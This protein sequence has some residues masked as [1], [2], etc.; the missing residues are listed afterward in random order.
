MRALSK[1]PEH[2]RLQR[3]AASKRYKER[4]AEKV[5]LSAR[6][7]RAIY[8][9]LNKEKCDA[10]RDEWAAKN[11][12]Y[13]LEYFKKYNNARKEKHKAYSKARY[14]AKNAE[15]KAQ[16]KEYR[17]RNSE[18]IKAD[19]A[20]WKS[21]NGERLK[22]SQAEYYQRSGKARRKFRRDTIPQVKIDS[23]CR[24]RIV[25]CLKNVGLK[26]SEKAETLLG[27]TAAFMK[28]FIEH[29]FELWMTWENW[30]TEWELD[31]TIPI[32][33]FDLTIKEQRLRAF[34]YSNCKPLRKI[35][36][37]MKNDKM[38]GPHQPLLI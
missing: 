23:C 7:Y 1:Y 6:K 11:R 2:I 13:Q 28:E 17:N 19:M 34:H 3:N 18:K 16:A 4:N 37:R 29:Q 22:A 14:I 32:S 10:S 27:C 30:G 33:S 8:Y 5:K 9:G 31:H 20:A 38:P 36:N 12:A 26:K 35:V 25:T 21:K 24:T 15:I